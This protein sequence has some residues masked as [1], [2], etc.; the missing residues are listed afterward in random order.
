VES[1]CI[2]NLAVASLP[3]YDIGRRGV[4]L[5][6]VFGIGSCRIIARKGL[7]CEKDIHV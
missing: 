2:E 6:R 3:G 1:G 7:G 5:S 4:E